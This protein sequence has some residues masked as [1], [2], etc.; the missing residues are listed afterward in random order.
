MFFSEERT[1]IFKDL[2]KL[3]KNIKQPKK[4]SDNPFFKS[5]YVNLEGVCESIDTA[6][7]ELDLGISYVQEL[8]SEGNQV[9]VTTHI[10]HDSG[11]FI[12]LD[13]LN[14]PVS[15]NDAQAFGSASTYAKRYALSAAFGVTSDVD[16]DGNGA[17]KN[18]T[19]DL[20]QVNMASP[21]QVG[22]L[23]LKIKEYCNLKNGNENEFIDF[24]SKKWGVVNIYETTSANVSKMIEFV[25]SN[26]KKDNDT[27]EKRAWD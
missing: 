24:L 19:K 1:E 7:R 2:S 16:D 9:S 25:S 8:T 10:L 11:Q 3:R 4:D 26:I 27:V 18:P 23:K 5:K 22:L 21:K 13:P 15:K 6:I 14:I 17:T 12:S 20:P